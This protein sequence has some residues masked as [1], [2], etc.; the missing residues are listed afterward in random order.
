MSE[1]FDPEMSWLCFSPSGSESSSLYT[2]D[3]DEEEEEEEE[4]ER[5][6]ASTEGTEAGGRVG[7]M[8]TLEEELRNFEV[9]NAGENA[10]AEAARLSTVGDGVLLEYF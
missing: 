9:T 10:K 6:E 8:Y 3:E 5:G 1:R 7:S 4:E 2:V